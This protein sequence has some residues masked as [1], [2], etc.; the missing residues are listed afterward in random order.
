MTGAKDLARFPQVDFPMECPLG[1][2]I[3][4]HGATVDNPC[5]IEDNEPPR[6]RDR[7]IGRIRVM[8]STLHMKAQPAVTHAR[9]LRRMKTFANFS[10][11]FCELSALKGR[12]LESLARLGGHSFLSLPVE[13]APTTLRLPTCFVATISYLKCFGRY[14]LFI[15]YRPWFWSLLTNAMTSLV[16]TRSVL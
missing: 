14:H 2:I 9:A 4:S 10:S 3:F 11:R 7:V 6:R 13:F 16:H 5:L 8:R 1:M 12:S 15:Y